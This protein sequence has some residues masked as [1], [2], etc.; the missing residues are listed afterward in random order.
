[1]KKI[2]AMLVVMATVSTVMGQWV[3]N[4]GNYADSAGGTTPGYAPVFMRGFLKTTDWYRDTTNCTYTKKYENYQV[5]LSFCQPCINCVTC[6]ETRELTNVVIYI[7]EKVPATRTAHVTVYPIKDQKTKIT[8][9]RK[10]A[11]ETLVGSVATE[12]FADTGGVDGHA[13]YGTIKPIQ[14]VGDWNQRTWFTGKDEANSY[15]TYPAIMSIIRVLDGSVS[16]TDGDKPNPEFAAGTLNLRRDDN[17]T[18]QLMLQMAYKSA[19]NAAGSYN[20]F[21]DSCT[22]APAVGATQTCAEIMDPD[23]AAGAA[24]TTGIR[25]YIKATLGGYTLSPAGVLD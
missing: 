8:V 4:S 25:K 24:G 13:K 7:V 14:L 17:M 15:T 22:A 20:P 3:Y 5:Y 9:T 2:L 11:R 10:K 12:L 1:M 23:P 19:G 18:L 21:F 6:D 16:T